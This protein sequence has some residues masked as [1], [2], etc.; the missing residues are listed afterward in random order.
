MSSYSQCRISGGSIND[1]LART[2][3]S[4]NTNQLDQNMQN[5]LKAAREAFNR[6]KTA[7]MTSNTNGM[8]Q[9]AIRSNMANMMNA[10]KPATMNRMASSN[11]MMMNALSCSGMTNNNMMTNASNNMMTNRSA[12]YSN[13]SGTSSPVI[14]EAII[15]KNTAAF[16]ARSRN[17]NASAA[18]TRS[19]T[20]QPSASSAPVTNAWSKANLLS[21]RNQKVQAPSAAMQVALMNTLAS[22]R[23]VQ[24]QQQLVAENN[25]QTPS[26]NNSTQLQDSRQFLLNYFKERAAKAPA[27][28]A[29]S[30]F[31]SNHAKSSSPAGAASQYLANARGNTAARALG[32]PACQSCRQ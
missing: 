26:P 31:L 11:N 15:A 5:K 20:F 19:A 30:L 32:A 12:S 27:S 29:S 4:S 18:A 25:M 6:A 28:K 17:A 8:N 14:Q 1:C 2:S 9:A 3:S 16:Q 10:A 13:T 7:A 22:Q 21:A 23:G 24:L